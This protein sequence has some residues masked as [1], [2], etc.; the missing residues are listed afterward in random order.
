MVDPPHA[1][2]PPPPAGETP[3]VA[4]PRRPSL[5]IAAACLFVLIALVTAGSLIALALTQERPRWWQDVNIADPAVI[6]TAQSVENGMATAL[7][8]VRPTVPSAASARPW[9]IYITT[10][11]ANAW[12]GV[13][14]RGWLENQGAMSGGGVRWPDEV[15]PPQVRFEKGLIRVGSLV[16]RPPASEP[17]NTQA[18]SAA[19]RPVVQPDGS[20]WLTADSVA[21]GRL[22]VPPGWL[23][24]ASSNSGRLGEVSPDLA[25]LPQASRVLD[26]LAG[27]APMLSSAVVRLA[28]GRR[29]RILDIDPQPG[30]VVITCRTE[31][32][33]TARR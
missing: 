18:L 30:R 4:A 32:R 28:D 29:V 6:S 26:A 19:L 12:L 2:A 27:R 23:L 31:D 20:F 15:D 5:R 25:S 14:L 1:D 17:P 7:T 3:V 22:P 21:I 16:R 33:D 10:D 8:Q 13:R 24:P 9:K 11:Q